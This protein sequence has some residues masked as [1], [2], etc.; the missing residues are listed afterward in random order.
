MSA[1]PY[2]VGDCS[3]CYSTFTF[4]SSE[5]RLGE[6]PQKGEPKAQGLSLSKNSSGHY[7]PGAAEVLALRAWAR[8]TV[9]VISMAQRSEGPFYMF[10]ATLPTWIKEK[11]KKEQ[12]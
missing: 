1:G 5:G 3:P 4:R 8:D 11:K 7:H 6:A 12:L 10:C 2:D 9:G